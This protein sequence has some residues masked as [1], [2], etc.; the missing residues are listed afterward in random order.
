MRSLLADDLI[1]LAGLQAS[2]YH[3]LGSE[4]SV[5]AANESRME[6][7][8]GCVALETIPVVRW[9]VTCAPPEECGVGVG[10]LLCHYLHVEPG[11]LDL[12]GSGHSRQGSMSMSAIA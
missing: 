5:Q 9:Y 4:I 10:F 6:I 7:V 12:C 2:R 8:V 1:R 11:D 3:F